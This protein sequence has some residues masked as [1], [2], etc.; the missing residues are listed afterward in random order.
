[1]RVLA[2]LL[3]ALVGLAACSGEDEQTGSA[4]AA[5]APEP[6][7]RLVPLLTQGPEGQTQEPR[8]GHAT[9]RRICSSVTT[10]FPAAMS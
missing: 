4:S 1:M 10:S 3:A 9:A 2:L 7:P 8:I 6:D 5:S